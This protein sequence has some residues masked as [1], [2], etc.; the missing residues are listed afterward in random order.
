MTFARTRIAA[1]LAGPLLCLA[2]AGA[3][4]AKPPCPA[5]LPPGV[6][7]GAP[8]MKLAPAGAYH[9]DPSH[10]AVI[11]RVS[12]IGYSYS[13]FRFDKVHGDLVWDGAAPGKSTLTAIVE[14]GSIATPVPGFAADLAGPKFLKSAEFPEARFVSTAFHKIS[15]TRGKVDGD[16]TLM[17]KTHKVTFEV[18]LVGAGPGFGHARMGVHATTWINP[19]DYGVSPFLDRPIE[20]T[21]DAEFEKAG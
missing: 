20:L 1:C 17:G 4:A 6:S 15:A 10:S 9:M 18:E 3:A 5:N 2:I 11:A 7:C 19:G 14:P 16:L 8:D 21:I 13:V 12:H